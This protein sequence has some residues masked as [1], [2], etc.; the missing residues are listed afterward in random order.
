[1]RSYG[2]GGRGGHRK[3]EGT[4][5]IYIYTERAPLSLVFSSIRESTTLS[6][7]CGLISCIRDRRKYTAPL[8]PRRR[9]SSLSPPKERVFVV[10]VH[11]T[12][13]YT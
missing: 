11:Q 5:Y 4:V 2:G 6:V 1:M 10:H 3:Y 9:L 13:V 12:T 7:P 8:P